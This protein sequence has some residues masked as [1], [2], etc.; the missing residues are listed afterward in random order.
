MNSLQL[1]LEV[2]ASETPVGVLEYWFVR[3]GV[4]VKKRVDFFGLEVVGGD[5][6]LHDLKVDQVLVLS[7][8]DA[9]ALLSYPSEARLAREVVSE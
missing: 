6:S 1:A 9:F 7:P 2:A 8:P 4:R 5:A 3:D